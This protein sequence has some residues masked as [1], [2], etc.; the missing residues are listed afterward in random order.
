MRVPE[1]ICTPNPE[2]TWR[3]FR[4]IDDNLHQNCDAAMAAVRKAARHTRK[5]LEVTVTA[6]DA[7]SENIS[8]LAD[9]GDAALASSD[10]WRSV[11]LLEALAAL[12]AECALQLCRDDGDFSVVDCSSRV[13][14][15]A[16]AVHELT[17]VI[18]AVPSDY[19]VTGPALLGFG[20][21]TS[22]EACHQ[23][24]IAITP[25]TRSV[26]PLPRA[27]CSVSM[28][29]LNSRSGCLECKQ[30]SWV[31]ANGAC[32]VEFCSEALAAVGDGNHGPPPKLAISVRIGSH[33]MHSWVAAGTFIG[34]AGRE[35]HMVWRQYMREP[36]QRMVL[37]D[38]G[39]RIAVITAVLGRDSILEVVDVSR[40]VPVTVAAVRRTYNIAQPF[41]GE[42][43]NLPDRSSFA[44]LDIHAA[45]I[46]VLSFHDAV[47]L[48]HVA[49][50]Q[51]QPDA[52][53]SPLS[54][55]RMDNVIPEAKRHPPS[56]CMSADS[57]HLLMVLG[58][59]HAS[60][61]THVKQ[62]RRAFAIRSSIVRVYDAG[63]LQLVR[64]IDVTAVEHH[65]PG[66]AFN[67]NIMALS[68]V[69]G[70]P[71]IFCV[72]LEN[73]KLTTSS[74]S[75]S[76]THVAHVIRAFSAT[77][78]EWMYQVPLSGALP[79]P[80]F[81]PLA[82]GTFVYPNAAHVLSSMSVV[83]DTRDGDRRWAYPYPGELTA[84][85]KPALLPFNTSAKT[86]RDMVWTFVGIVGRFAYFAN[87][88]GYTMFMMT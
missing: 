68:F 46:R 72:A 81:I 78:G 53:S 57:T 43:S 31:N 55:L 47:E 40:Q 30:R 65:T 61:T 56:A 42:L 20:L 44:L 62:H 1:L 83:A 69:H 50:S 11:S 45:L 24:R 3:A 34:A 37:S 5:A 77:S 8:A 82:N 74:T 19:D 75:V 12:D 54:K 85:E 28:E 70:T 38:D 2:D 67:A 7:F 49:V 6:L 86:N 36:W 21:G 87:G 9:A 33:V 76:A 10:G 41:A 58:P 64:W 13:S 84:V 14:R 17:A 88:F 32:C 29:I 39:S 51:L 48:R 80:W 4:D 66:P 79:E 25:R 52:A 26:P 59:R 16:T 63:T 27:A 35:S 60:F 15:V 73:T 71:G 18:D 22:T 23:N